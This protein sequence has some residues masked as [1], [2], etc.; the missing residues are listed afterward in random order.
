LNERIR[1]EELDGW[2]KGLNSSL[3]EAIGEELD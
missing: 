3:E 2:K 1:G